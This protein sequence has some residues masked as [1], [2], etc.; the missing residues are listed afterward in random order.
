M[1]CCGCPKLL[2]IFN[3]C[4]KKVS[5]SHKQWNAGNKW[6]SSSWEQI[7]GKEQF[8]RKK[9]FVIF[10]NNSSVAEFIRY[11]NNKV[12]FTLTQPS[13]SSNSLNQVLY[14]TE[15]FEPS[16]TYNRT[17]WTK[18]IKYLYQYVQNQVYF[19]TNCSKLTTQQN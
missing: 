17:I 12:Y 3:F 2:K 6:R 5:R 1:G 19:R 13:W 14:I 7:V 16:F 4:S 15:Q 18:F 10:S 8:V 11:S 9:I